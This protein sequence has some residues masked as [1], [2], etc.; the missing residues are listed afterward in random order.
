M[1]VW[2][3]SGRFLH[4]QLLSAS[5]RL[6]MPKEIVRELASMT[7][8][9]QQVSGAAARNITIAIIPMDF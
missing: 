4:L 8:T 2:A 9:V 7:H 3:S 6:T 1:S 5:I